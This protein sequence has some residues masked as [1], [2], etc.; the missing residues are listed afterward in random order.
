MDMVIR[1][2]VWLTLYTCVAESDVSLG[3]FIKPIPRQVVQF[4]PRVVSHN[5]DSLCMYLGKLSDFS[6]EWSLNTYQG[7]LSDFFESCH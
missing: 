7:K 5:G 2:A 4:L 3:W 6:Q 1:Q